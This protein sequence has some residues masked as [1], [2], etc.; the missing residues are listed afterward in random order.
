MQLVEV[1]NAG[2]YGMPQRRRRV[3]ILG[4]TKIQIFIKI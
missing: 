4:Y 3:F 1:I 2:D